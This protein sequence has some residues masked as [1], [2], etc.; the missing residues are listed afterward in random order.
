MKKLILVLV[1]LMMAALGG[2]VLAQGTQDIQIK[3]TAIETRLDGLEAGV[4]RLFTLILSL[5][6]A[7]IAALAGLFY[8]VFDIS[9]SLRTPKEE[10]VARLEQPIL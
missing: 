9:K 3:L 7:M 6:G 8:F 5:F 10:R 4:N 2:A 1:I